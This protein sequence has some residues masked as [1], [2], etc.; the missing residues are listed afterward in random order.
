MANN[1]SVSAVQYLDNPANSVAK[2]SVFGTV[3]GVSVLCTVFSSA[4]DNAFAA[5]GQPGLQNYLGPLMLAASQNIY[6][7]TTAN[8]DVRWNGSAPSGVAL[9][10]NSPGSWTV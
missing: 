1:Y 9:Y 5:N 3:N 4:L 10:P 2:V 8:P 6:G 7:P